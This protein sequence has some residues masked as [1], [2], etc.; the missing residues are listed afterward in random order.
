MSASSAS[1][2]EEP[3]RVALLSPCYW[4]EVMRG[5][6]RIVRELANGL[7]GRGHHPSL[8]TSHPA[9]PVRTVEDGMPVLR[10]PRPPQRRLLRRHY[11]PYLTHV[12]L[13][14]LALRAGSYD[15]GHAVYPTDAL[16]AG[17]WRKR[18]GRPAL[19]SYM[20]IPDRRGLCEF[21]GGIEIMLAAVRGCDAVVTLSRHA[22]EAAQRWLGR[23][24]HVI[25][26]GVDLH[27]F[28][29]APARSERPTIVCTA[30]VDV[31]RKNVALLV[32]AFARVRDRYPQARLV[33]VRPQDEAAARRAGVKLEQPGLEWIDHDHRRS[34]L[35]R[36]YGEAWVAV[37]PSV[38]EAFGLVLAEALA[39]G[40]P[41]VGHADAAIPEII[42]RP[43]IGQLFDRLDPD[44]LA[45]ALLNALEL[46]S[47]PATVGR[48]RA[49]AEEFSTE[50]SADRYLALY[51]ELLSN[52]SS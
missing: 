29:P 26:P 39:C 48:C 36:A 2:G 19:M 22:A 43:E 41:V 9:L 3:M 33:L 44:S 50:R 42:D 21:R 35:S 23:E 16:A 17:H 24:A 40:T 45:R 47:D 12:P 27:A 7:L 49:R 34:N 15:I 28:V 31:T 10:L 32:E 38:D 20:G 30:A 14:Y 4:P 6:E 5:T 37:L 8:I 25:P 13:S 1:A 52:S 11:Q 18:T 46:A 51:R